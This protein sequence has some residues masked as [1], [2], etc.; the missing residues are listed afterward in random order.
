MKRKNRPNLILIYAVAAVIL[1]PGIFILWKKTGFS[2]LSS[3]VGS[4]QKKVSSFISYTGGTFEP[5]AGYVQGKNGIR[6]LAAR[7]LELNNENSALKAENAAL[8][9]SSVLRQYRDFKSSI[10][11]QARVIGANDDGFINYYTI[12]RGSDDYVGE[13]DGVVTKDGVVCMIVKVSHH[14]RMVQLLTAVKSSISAR[15]ERSRVA[16]ILSGE[17]CS[18]C[19]ISFVLKDEDIKEGD[20][21]VTS[22]L[23]KS[24]P[25]GMRLGTVKKIDK[26][27]SGIS[28]A[29]TIK[30]FVDT[31]EVEEVLVVKKR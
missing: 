6:I 12:D 25:E 13:G 5:G 31:F 22:G 11:C 21:I 30:P 14:T 3:S 18:A 7:N 9:R 26:N 4:A 10:V 28:M 29:I 24:F 17:S 23:G 16:G 20:V 2:F 8:A 15:D 19:S 1:L 27:V